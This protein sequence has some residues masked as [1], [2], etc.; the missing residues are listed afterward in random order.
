MIILRILRKV[1][2]KC[3][4][5]KRK[6]LDCI[7]D[8]SEASK[9]IYEELK[10]DKP[11]MIARFGAV[12]WENVSNYMA[13]KDRKYRSIQGY[14]TGE[15][16]AWWWQENAV[17]Q[18]KQNA[19]FFPNTKENV[20]KFSELFLEDIKEIDILG[21]WLPQEKLLPE[22]K[23]YKKI[24]LPL[25]EPYWSENPWSYILKNKKVLII[26]P[27]KDSIEKQYENR[28]HLFLNNKILPEFKSL[29]VIKAVQSIGGND[30]FKDWFEALNHMK[31]EIDK[32]DYDICLI[33]AGA[34]GL[35]LAA[36]VKRKGKKSIHLGGSLQ[37]LFGIKGNRWEDP[38]YEFNWGLKKGFY[39][40]L[41]DNPYWIRAEKSEKPKDAQKVENACYW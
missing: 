20:E 16:P 4:N 5:K 35:H 30:K 18:L 6:M 29:T 22:Y 36:Y 40:K 19:G 25:L 26:H 32:K 10:S 2:S 12:E 15:T 34:Y 41:L 11:V 31:K 17:K 28:N 27:F 24:L 21:S 8:P 33:G 7:K 1:Y 9:I 38:N 13:I 23:N 3:T 14:I 39:K 37:L